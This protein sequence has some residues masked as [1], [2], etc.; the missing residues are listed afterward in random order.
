MFF[1]REEVECFESTFQ[2]ALQFSP[3]RGLYLIS[4][5][6][7]YDVYTAHRVINIDAFCL[8]VYIAS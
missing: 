6:V 2:S 4:Y 1:I 7:S 8:L 3:S 5:I